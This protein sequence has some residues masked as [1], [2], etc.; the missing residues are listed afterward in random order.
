MN[1]GTAVASASYA[2]RLGDALR[3]ADGRR[4]EAVARDAFAAG[5]SLA[6][7]YARVVAPA[8]YWIGELW[9]RRAI[10]VADE[11]AAAA[12]CHG[13]IASLDPMSGSEPRDLRATVL[14]AAPSG[15]RHGL[16]LRMAADVLERAA[17]HVI[18]LGTD[19][20]VDALVQSV[21]AYEPAI[22]GLSMTMP[23]PRSD[24]RALLALIGQASGAR[25]LIGGQGVPGALPDDRVSVIAGVESVV[26][27]VKRMLT[28]QTTDAGQIPDHD[29]AEE[30]F[31][32][33]AAAGR[34]VGE[35]RVAR[36]RVADSEERFRATFEDAPIG[37]ALVALGG[38]WLRVNPALVAM[39][40]Y[41][42]RELAAR[43]VRDI[44]HPDDLD[45]D[46]QGR[47]ALLAGSRRT[48]EFDK[49]YLRADGSTL[50]ARVSLSVVRDIVGT[51][52]HY[53]AHVQ[54]ITEA[55]A[56]QARA[57]ALQDELHQAMR[58][59]SLGQLAAGV[60]HDFNNYLGVIGLHAHHAQNHV[61]RGSPAR[62]DLQEIVAAGRRAA[63][64]TSELLAFG[65]QNT[66]TPEIVGINS[67]IQGLR[68]LLS[69]II[70]ERIVLRTELDIA[71]AHA[72]IDR[73]QLDQVLV[74]LTANARDA[75]A[76]TGQ[77][78]I[79]T[80]NV[81]IPADTPPGPGHPA[82]RRYV[83][84]EV[85][86]TG[87]GMSAETRQRAF[88]PFFTTKPSTGGTGLGLAGVYAIVAQAYG[89]ISLDSE[90][91]SG[92]T[93]S[94]LLPAT[95]PPRAEGE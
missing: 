62:T 27:Q 86:D 42:E 81:T 82:P 80:A 67:A 44:T 24:I 46:L 70:G 47:T 10:T 90:P 13:V 32:R 5:L 87:T 77:I 64:L 55:K 36:R 25:V 93:V 20:P 26:D 78:T 8:M 60:A 89:T 3:A 92:T 53:V 71:V 28:T 31:A 23:R 45:P 40:G 33:G 59:D 54:D 4:A 6:A 95:D 39:T 51:P 74:N 19:V 57:A 21:A 72:R 73:Q 65:R 83:L 30:V 16:G 66:A 35:R 91:G 37:V 68:G 84:V 50:S 2:R 29:T 1:Q 58:L 17:F 69:R 11:H 43:T 15:E 56:E 61:A 94:I 34:E 12:I 85:Q 75:I 79:R 9:E 63:A 22:V 38:R 48:L 49:R 88:E 41:S 52:M 76:H 7:V 14:L 18:Y